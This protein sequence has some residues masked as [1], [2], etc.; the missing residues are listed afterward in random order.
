MKASLSRRILGILQNKRLWLLE[1]FI[2]KSGHED[3][4][5]VSDIQRGFDPTGALPKSGVF[6][7]KFR[8]ARMTCED[9]RRVSNLGRDALLDSVQSAG[10]HETD[11]SLFEATMKELEKGFIEGPTACQLGQVNSDQTFPSEAEEK[12][13]PIDDYKASLANFAVTQTEGVTIHTIDHIAAMISWWMRSGSL[14][15]CDGR[16]AECWELSDA[17]KQVPL[18]EEAFD[19]DSYLAVYKAPTVRQQRS[20]NSVS[21]PLDRWPRSQL[22]QSVAGFVEDWIL[23]PHVVSLL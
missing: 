15:P 14:S 20:S 4:G 7:H 3:V 18:S 2:A 5:L 21:C 13:G 19:L 17:Y 12:V 16:M 10:D 6:N 8:P 9:L 23:S 1:T 22:S 11:A